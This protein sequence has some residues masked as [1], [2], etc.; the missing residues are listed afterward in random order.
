MCTYHTLENAN[1]LKHPLL[2][3]ETNEISKFP[4]VTNLV[5]GV[6]GTDTQ[7]SCLAM[8]AISCAS[9]WLNSMKEK[10]DKWGNIKNLLHLLAPCSD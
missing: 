10:H 1:L 3:G 7:V 5:G 8:Q 9:C 2:D 4:S 6:A